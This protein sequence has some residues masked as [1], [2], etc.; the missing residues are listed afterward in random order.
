MRQR[1]KRTVLAAACLAAAMFAACNKDDQPV[2][3]VP[4]L[5]LDQ[6]C[7]TPAP[8]HRNLHLAIAQQSVI[9][10][11]VWRAYPGWTIPVAIDSSYKA[12]LAIPTTDG[13]KYDHQAFQVKLESNQW[14]IAQGSGEFLPTP[15][16]IGAPM[17]YGFVI[18]PT[19]PKAAPGVVNNTPP[20]A[21]MIRIA[22][23]GITAP[24]GKPVAPIIL[25]VVDRREQMP[26]CPDAA[27]PNM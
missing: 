7:V 27:P 1:V 3:T 24:D 20:S 5:P 14:A 11:G 19:Q 25:R 18:V 4:L 23:E 13:F 17:A 8:Q 22:L 12:T 26:S 15:E 2:P 21:S 10:S 16:N 9:R 6:S